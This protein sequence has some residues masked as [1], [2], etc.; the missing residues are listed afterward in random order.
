MITLVRARIAGEVGSHG[1]PRRRRE[2][3]LVGKVHAVLKGGWRGQRGL[4]RGGVS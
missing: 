4:G 2:E 1:D 3:E